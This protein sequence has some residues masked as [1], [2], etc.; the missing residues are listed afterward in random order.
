[1]TVETRQERMQIR[2]ADNLV[3][4]GD[5]IEAV[6]RVD[7]LFGEYVLTAD[8]IAGNRQSKQFR[9]EGKAKVDGPS[10]V[11]T[12]DTIDVNLREKTFAFSNGA[13]KLE[14]ERLRKPTPGDLFVEAKEG[15]GES[16]LV[17]AI[18]AET[19]TCDLEHPHFAIRS[20]SV[21]VVPGKRADLRNVVVS[22]LGKTV[23]RL[24]MVSIPLERGSQRWLPTVGQ[25]P[26]EGYYVKARVTTP[27]PGE[28]FVDTR[29]D[30][31]SR[32][33]TG[34][35]WD[36]NYSN[37]SLTGLLSLYGLFG[38]RRSTLLT[39]RHEHKLFGGT[40]S[41]FGSYQRLNY[42]TAPDSTVTNLS[43]QYIV[44]RT[45]G[46]TR[47][48]YQRYGSSTSGFNAADQS[49][50]LSDSRS[51]GPLRSNLDLALQRN[52]STGGSS[53]SVLERFDVRHSAATNF[54]SFEAELMYSRTVPI[55]RGERVFAGND[56]TPM[57]TLRSDS[58]RLIDPQVGR[59]WPVRLSASIGEL[60]NLAG[61]DRVTRLYFASQIGRSEKMGRSTTMS[62]ST[63]FQQGL[64]SDD[65]AQYVLNHQATFKQSIGSKGSLGVQYRQLR[66]FGFSPV[67]IDQTGQTDALALDFSVSPASAVLLSAQSGYDFNYKRVFGSPWRSIWLRG[68]WDPGSR[69]RLDASANYDTIDQRWSN[70]RVDF[71][72]GKSPWELGL[73]VR[74]DFANE[75][76]AGV[77]ARL[78]G[79]RYGR[80][81]FRM[82]LD[83]NGYSKQLEAQHYQ[84]VYDLHCA[85]AVFEVI[86][87]RIGF[88]SGRT[89]GLYLRI[90]AFPSESLFGQ[91]T[92]G[93]AV[94]SGFGFGD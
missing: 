24:P 38:V 30:L 46:S 5:D 25:S 1:M 84:A 94:G 31:M 54:R 55:G 15:G 13:A 11:V 8:K 82:L 7:M 9:L 47:L 71:L 89:F 86:D 28:N 93:Q 35:G 42:L 63:E 3:L 58:E 78:V 66:P 59:T 50:G 91:G 6:G 73:G 70:L 18:E 72:T 49:F 10:E 79:A 90:K 19:T 69:L 57:L 16:G 40:L 14:P 27:L 64:Y 4:R 12:G 92:R 87:N 51:I 33:G 65:T 83:Y 53:R 23:I 77:S 36:Y 68:L 32:L 43:G 45:Q 62:W 52:E 48:T 85:E 67:S 26:D 88:R 44:P 74:Y 60:S 22:V 2:S 29:L 75:S 21:K 80:T 20:K 37:K 61:Q 81:G 34:L 41:S 56:V 39:S 17:T 76:L